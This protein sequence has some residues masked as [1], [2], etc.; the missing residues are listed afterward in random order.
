MA[1]LKVTQLRSIIGC[2]QNQRDTIRTLGLRKIRQSVVRE[3]TPQVRGL[4]HTV[5]HLVAVEEVAD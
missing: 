5:R 1:K 2:K 4:I 3:D